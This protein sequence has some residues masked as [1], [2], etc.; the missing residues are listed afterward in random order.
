MISPE[1]LTD[2]AARFATKVATTYTDEQVKEAVA[3]ETAALEY[4]TQGA[5]MQSAMV[6]VLK[7]E[8]EERGKRALAEFDSAWSAM[9]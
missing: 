3:L 1:E 9:Q 6:S 8:L 4:L 5:M 2:F 7:K